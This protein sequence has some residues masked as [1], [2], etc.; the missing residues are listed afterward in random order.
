ML[1]KILYSNSFLLVLVK[2][3]THLA[4]LNE[5]RSGFPYCSLYPYITGYITEE[6]CAYYWLKSGGLVAAGAV[7][8]NMTL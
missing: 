2:S 7:R 8:F 3:K 5:T 1:K 6:A 4:A